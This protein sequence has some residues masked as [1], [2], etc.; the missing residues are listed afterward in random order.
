MGETPGKMY[1]LAVVLT[2]LAIA[3]VLLRLYARRITK[4]R[5][6]WDD[7]MVFP[8]LLFT[9]GTAGCMFVGAAI[10]DLGRH[11]EIGP[12]GL[13]VLTHHT[14]VFLIIDFASQLTQ[15]LTFGFT[16]IAVLLFYNRI[17]G[18][19]NFGLLLYAMIGL[20]IGWTIAFFFAN[21][22]QCM[23]ISENWT[24][25]G[26][27]VET[28]I[29]T[30]D[31]YLGQAYSD[32]IS[33]ALI[34]SLPIPKIWTLQL[35]IRRKLAVNGI[36]FLGTLVVGAGIAKVVVFRQIAVET[37]SNDLDLSY[38]LSPTLYWPMIESSLGIVGA[39]LPLMRPILQKISPHDVFRSLRSMFEFSTFGSA[40]SLKTTEA[41]TKLEVECSPTSTETSASNMP[42]DSNKW[43]H[44]DDRFE[45]IE[46]SPRSPSGKLVENG[47][48]V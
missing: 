32:V 43:E 28:C 31:M 22:F 24:G 2:L 35:P 1:A 6:E 9:I 30:V 39:C 25:Y 20:M 4:Q 42:R 36:F 23:P 45:D 5:L 46:I 40:S 12:D 41:K 3:A 18:G 48:I 44:S 11:T 47:D 29:K 37:L 19:G 26:G 34:L 17:F 27:T 13:P 7:Y 15:T 21:L 38:M 8:A 14:E 10:G 16:K 33:D